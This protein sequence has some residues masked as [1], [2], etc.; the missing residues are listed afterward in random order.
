MGVLFVRVEASERMTPI[1]KTIPTVA[2]ELAG[3][4]HVPVASLVPFQG[5]LKELTEREYGK[6]KKS[7]LENNLIVPFFVW[8]ETGKLLDGHQRQRVFMR[9]GWQMDVPVVYISADSEQDAKRKLLVISSQYG[10]MTQEGFDSFTFDLDDSWIKETVQFDALPFVFDFEETPEPETADA[11]PQVN[12]AEELRQKWQ[13]EP[14]QLWRLPSRTPGQEH[15][16]IVGDCTD[17][18]VVERVMGGEKA[19]MI[20]TDPPYGIDYNRHIPNQKY[21]DLKNDKTP[22]PHEL[23]ASFPPAKASYVWCRWDVLSVWLS[24]MAMPVRNVIVW[25]KKTHGMGDLSTTYAP[26][27]EA[28]IFC[29]EPGH[30]LNDGRLRDVWP[31]ERE[32]EDLHLTP[33]PISVMQPPI[34]KSTKLGGIIFDGF[35]GAAPVIVSAENL[36]R[37]ARAVEISPGYVAVAL[38]RYYDAFGIRAELITEETAVNG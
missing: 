25:D 5:E 18:D 29:S 32:T 17:G 27:W 3:L 4:D 23:M 13:V 21:K 10:H 14:G 35:C 26:S 8:L 37:Q 12:R 11:E 6:L 38:Q 33:K 24:A 15:R 22:R 1:T 16:L 28:C 9:E 34:E 2:K 30:K 7:I 36:N 20:L 19:D 31:A